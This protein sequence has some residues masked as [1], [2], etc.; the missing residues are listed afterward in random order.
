MKKHGFRPVVRIVRNC[1][2]ALAPSLHLCEN[3]LKHLI[4]KQT[5]RLLL[6]QLTRRRITSHIHFSQ[7]ER[8]PPPSAKFFHK[9]SILSCFRA[10]TVI[11]MHHCQ[12]ERDLP[13]QPCQQMQHA[14]RIRAAG[15]AGCN[16][17]SQFHHTMGF[18]IFFYFLIKIIFHPSPVRLP[19]PIKGTLIL[20]HRFPKGNP[21]GPRSPSQA[22][23]YRPESAPGSVRSRKQESDSQSPPGCCIPSFR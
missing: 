8:N 2:S 3:F 10:Q 21:P 1:N 6:R 18:Y 23:S 22:P 20:D 15:N 9:C 14:N 4:A 12:P 5:P 11:H 19:F 7:I 13:L 17:V 16:A